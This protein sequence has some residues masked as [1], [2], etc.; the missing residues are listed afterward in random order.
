MFLNV[1]CDASGT[2]DK[3]FE[4]PLDTESATKFLDEHDLNDVLNK[5]PEEAFDLLAGELP[6][7]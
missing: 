6:S 7:W 2:I 4:L 5:L 3:S 1:L